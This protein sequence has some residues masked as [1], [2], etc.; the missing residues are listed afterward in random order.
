M[1][2]SFKKSSWVVAASLLVGCSGGSSSLPDSASSAIQV[3]A[4]PDPTQGQGGAGQGGAS[5]AGAGGS[6]GAKSKPVANP[7]NPG[8]PWCGLPAASEKAPAS[9]SSGA[10]W[11][12]GGTWDITIDT[13]NN[14]PPVALT[15]DEFGRFV[16]GAAGADVCGSPQMSG[17]YSLKTGLFEV[18]SVQG[19]GSCTEK[20][21]AGYDVTFSAD[22]NQATLKM[23]YDNCTGGALLQYG[24]SMKRR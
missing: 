20:W 15:F 21:G 19:N 1:A 2:V 10:C 18:L 22:C 17:T 7:A 8:G 11:L 16:T 23:K 4:T 13:W 3:D 14:A 12:V 24:G 5:G 9:L 6:A